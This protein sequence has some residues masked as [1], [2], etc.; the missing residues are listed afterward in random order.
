MNK[1]ELNKCVE[2]GLRDYLI[3]L[4]SDTKKPIPKKFQING[5]AEYHW[6]KNPITGEYI[7]YTDEE[8]LNATRI[9]IN[10]EAGDLV[11]TD[12]DAEECSDFMSVLPPTLT[13]TKGNSIRQKLYKVN[14]YKKTTK[15]KHKDKVV[16]EV[17][18]NTQ[19]WLCGDGKQIN[20]VKPSEIEFK[21]LLEEVKRLMLGPY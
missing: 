12:G 5:H 10:H 14:G 11:A 3:P 18:T 7:K 15:Y 20:Y 21:D 16:I 2:L 8:L 13:V 6:K 9:G 4:S 17:L 19:S 1:V